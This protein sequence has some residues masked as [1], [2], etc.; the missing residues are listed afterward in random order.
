MANQRKILCQDRKVRVTVST[1]YSPKQEAVD[2]LSTRLSKT[3]VEAVWRIICFH[4]Y[5]NQSSYKHAD[6]LCTHIHPD[7]MA[8]CAHVRLCIS[9][10]KLCNCTK[11]RDDL[12]RA[13]NCHEGTWQDFHPRGRFLKKKFSPQMAHPGVARRIFPVTPRVHIHPPRGFMTV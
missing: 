6:F 4:K 5:G 8:V 1:A 2:I 3:F 11:A 12:G 7:L 13:S 10:C 9:V